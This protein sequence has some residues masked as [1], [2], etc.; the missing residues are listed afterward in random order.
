VASTTVGM[1]VGR[2]LDLGGPLAGAIPESRYL[3]V[4]VA[5]DS[6]SDWAPTLAAIAVEYERLPGSMRRRWQLGVIAR[7][8]IIERD[9]GQHLRSGPEIVA[10]LWQAW[11]QG[12][13]IPFR[14][15]DYDPDPTERQVRVIGLTEQ[16]PT[17]SSTIGASQLTV[18]LLEM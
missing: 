14:D 2:T 12:T 1:G 7:D 8:R 11:E 10:D 3:Q 9:G 4:Q 17:P 6:V 16:I 15:I 5:W 18:T 13:T